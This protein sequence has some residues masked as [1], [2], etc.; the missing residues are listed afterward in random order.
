MELAVTLQISIIVGESNCF[1][2]QT[3]KVSQYPLETVGWQTFTP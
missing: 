1:M 2:F 3:L